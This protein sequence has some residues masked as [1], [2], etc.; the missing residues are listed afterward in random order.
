MS[1]GILTLDI[2]TIPQ[3]RWVDPDQVGLDEFEPESLE[4]AKTDRH[5]PTFWKPS[6]PGPLSGISDERDSYVLEAVRAG[7]MKLRAT[8]T[9]PAC[10]ATTCHV[11]SVA[12][13]VE[14]PSNRGQVEANIPE[15]HVLTLDQ[16]RA[17]KKRKPIQR[18]RDIERDRAECILIL[19][20]LRLLAKYQTKGYRV[21]TFNGK[22]FDLP[23]LRWRGA[24]LLVVPPSLPWDGTRGLLY[25]W[26]HSVH[27]DLRLSFSG[28]LYAKGTLEWWSKAFGV[29]VKQVAHGGDVY[30]MLHDA[31]GWAKLEKYGHEEARALLELYHRAEEYL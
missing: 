26:G 16:L 8:G 28:S 15:T 10:H 24:M 30:E 29:K 7:S 23:I 17:T 3:R 21:V 9:V 31:R 25:P 6:P 12:F 1:S 13:G 5:G 19:D 27:A 4:E 2:E 14:H 11:V 22:G 20:S 18:W